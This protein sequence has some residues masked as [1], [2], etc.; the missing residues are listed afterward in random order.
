[1]NN[2]STIDNLPPT[3]RQ[4]II[5]RLIRG[6]SAG[7]IAQ[8]LDI[9]RAAVQAYK[10]RYIKPALKAA[11]LMA[12]ASDTQ[13][14]PHVPTHDVLANARNLV[15]TSPT[16]QRA[17]QVYD[18]LM[19]DTRRARAAVQVTKDGD[20]IGEDMAILP[21]FYNQL[22]KNLELTGKLTGEIQDKSG[23]PVVN[24]QVVIP[25]GSG[26]RMSQNLCDGDVIECGAE[27][28]SN[29][30]GDSTTR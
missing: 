21:P 8:E 22:H 30:P 23:A 16:Q 26:V 28:I 1:V 7:L 29:G 13:L 25:A 17:S 10:A 24:V 15:R 6:E 18:M 3:E 12:S 14:F 4:R 5:D 20:P 2:R 27:E 19:K 11:D 9:S